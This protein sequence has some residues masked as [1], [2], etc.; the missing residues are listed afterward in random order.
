MVL[1]G[2]SPR[3]PPGRA[4]LR[5]TVDVLAALASI[6][7]IAFAFSADRQWLDRHFLPPFFVTRVVYLRAAAVVRTVLVALAI[8]ILLARPR[9]GR[10][11]A[12]VPARRFA[13]DTVSILIAVALA[14]GASEA[15]LRLTFR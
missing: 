15:V 8:L 5:A 4:V 6:S 13:T 14:L 12:R 11:V 2:N 10:F 7:L 1:R 9:I 3:L